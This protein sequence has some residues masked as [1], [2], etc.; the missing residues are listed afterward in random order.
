MIPAQAS[1]FCREPL[2]NQYNSARSLHF[3]VSQI[4]YSVFVSVLRLHDSRLHYSKNTHRYFS[5]ADGFDVFTEL[6][7]LILTPF[8]AKIQK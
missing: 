2:L 8:V 4:L 3:A 7:H 1:R 5:A 6:R